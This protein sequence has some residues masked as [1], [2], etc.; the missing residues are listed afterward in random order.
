MTTSKLTILH[1]RDLGKYPPILNLIDYLRSSQ[2][3]FNPITA[4]F[5]S[6]KRILTLLSYFI[7]TLKSL[8][9]LVLSKNQNI[10]YFESISAVPVFIYFS[11][12]PF[13][14]KKLFIHYHEYFSTD[15]YLRQSFLERLG[16]KLEIKL[17]KRAIWISH[18]NK[19]RLD[20]FHKE[21]PYLSNSVLKTLPNYPPS[22]WL[23]A[24]KQMN[25]AQTTDIIKLVHIGA[26]STD[27]MYLENVLKHFGN[28]PKFTIDFYSHKFTTEITALISSYSNC[29]IKG[30]IAYQDIPTIKGL[31]DV[32]LVLY[33]GISNNV[34][35]CAPNK[36][37]EYLALDLDVWCSDKLITASEHERLDCYP[38]MIMVD[39][40]NLE[41]FD[42]AKATDKSGL[43]YVPSPYVCDPVYEKLLKQILN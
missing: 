13:S 29:S 35:Y 11:L 16:R 24:P 12:F 21:F 39:Y 37:F 7:F 1:F 27:G 17:F 3:K 14:R 19:H 25:E 33:K 4:S 10:L 38:K 22:S 32:G 40:E 9:K 36:I 23:R 6:Q 26:L 8:S 34:K 20:L 2:I 5:T 41:A 15:E 28:N 30:S 42:V 43:E 18:T 31:Y